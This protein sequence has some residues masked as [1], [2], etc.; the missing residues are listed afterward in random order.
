V[1]HSFGGYLAPRA[2][3]FEKRIKAVI[4]NPTRPDMDRTIKSHLGLDPDEDYGPDVESKLD[5]SDGTVRLIREGDFLWRCGM[6][7]ASIPDLLEFVARFRL[8]G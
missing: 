1:G 8:H 6:E 3:A 5:L 7:G 2:A 4:A